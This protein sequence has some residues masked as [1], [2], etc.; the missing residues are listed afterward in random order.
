MVTALI[1]CMV[2]TL[3][4]C[5]W[6]DYVH[7]DCVDHVHGDC[8]DHVHGDCVDH[9]HGDCVTC[10]FDPPPDTLEMYPIIYFAATVFPAPLS[11]LYHHTNNKFTLAPLHILTNT[12][13]KKKNLP[14]ITYPHTKTHTHTHTHTHTDRHT[15]RKTLYII[16][17][18]NT[19]PG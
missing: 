6:V 11:P 2:T 10:T 7:G 18:T 14:H 15:C 5:D 4:M 19:E 8:V 9:V 12:Q 17:I 3:I 1:V 16:I 13:T